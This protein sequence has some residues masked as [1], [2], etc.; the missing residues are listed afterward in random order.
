MNSGILLS[1]SLRNV[2]RHGRRSVGTLIVMAVSVLS[3]GVLFGYVQANLS[4]TRDAFMRWGARGHLVIERPASPLAQ[5]FEGAAQKPIDLS[6][7]REIG[8][9]LAGD[10]APEAVARVLRISGMVS[11]A[12]VTTVF[13]GLGEDVAA[14]RQIKGPAYEYDVVAGRPL[15][16]APR[17]DDALLG[18]GLAGVL[19]CKVPSAG[20]APLRPGEQPTQ[21]ELACPPGPAQLSVV[22]EGTGHVNAIYVRPGG[23]IDWGIREVNE[24]L[25][26]LPLATAQRMMNSDHVSAFHVLLRDGEDM[27]AAQRRITAEFERRQLDAH[28]FLWS[29]RAAFY[30]QVRGVLLSFFVFVLAIAMIVSFM[31]LLNASYMNF[32]SRRREFATLRSFGYTRG[33]VM[34]LAALENAWLAIAAL[35]GIAGALA[36]T[37]VV[38]SAGWMWT[39]PGSSNAVPVTI[40][41]VPHVYLASMIG[42]VLLAMLAS[43]I[44]LRRIL[45]MPIRSALADA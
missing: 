29:D 7:Q 12:N 38:R 18:Q 25:V 8:A 41:W 20:F 21:R 4:L 40:E 42:L 24:R 19:G 17:P 15:W 16:M 9:V 32:M 45:A 36:V 22:T 11:G 31:S 6:M 39:P 3:L 28:V 44:P 37:A 1:L 5:L 34:R 10:A 26:V 14:T 33:F 30:W 43:L 23:I 13:A 27:R 2:L 35:P